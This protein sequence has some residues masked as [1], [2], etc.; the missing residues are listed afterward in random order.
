MIMVFV[1]KNNFTNDVCKLDFDFELKHGKM[2]VEF[3]TF[4]Q[5][6]ICTDMS[7]MTQ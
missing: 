6:D 3:Y 2:C 7:R 5:F 4:P 1:V